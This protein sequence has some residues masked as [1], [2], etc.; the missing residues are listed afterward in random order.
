MLTYHNTTSARGDCF[1]CEISEQSQ[2]SGLRADVEQADG[3][4]WSRA[5]Q[6][7]AN[8]VLEFK[9]LRLLTLKGRN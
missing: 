3:T 4:R 2:T 8:L 7:V 9:K 1:S 5:N 6:S